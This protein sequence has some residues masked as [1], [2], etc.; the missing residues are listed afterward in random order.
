VSEGKA[1][2]GKEKVA[3]WRIQHGESKVIQG[4]LSVLELLLTEC[5]LA[6][7]VVSPPACQKQSEEERKRRRRKRKKER[8][9]EKRTTS[10]ESNQSFHEV[11]GQT[12]QGTQDRQAEGQR[13]K[14]QIG[15][16]K[17]ELM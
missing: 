14:G 15:K 8:N 16:F 1:S 2:E 10:A 5:G 12:L 4:L 3:N 7:A 17:H 6:N 9:R 13:R 11:A